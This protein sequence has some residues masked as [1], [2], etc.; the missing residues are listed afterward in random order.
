MFVVFLMV[1]VLWGIGAA[2]KAPRKQRWIMTG[3]VLGAVLI[4]QLVLPDGHPLREATGSSPMLW[5]LIFAGAGLVYVYRLGLGRLRAASAPG[6]PPVQTD[7]SKLTAFE[8]DRYARHIV[9]RE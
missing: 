1:A 7:P 3:V 5:V 9:L 4:I 8:L 2:M 6:D